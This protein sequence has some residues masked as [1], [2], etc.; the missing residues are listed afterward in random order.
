ML[1]AILL[2][3]V[4]SIYGRKVIIDCDAGVDDI[5][6]IQLLLSEPEVE[7]LAITT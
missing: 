6:A 1:F 5:Y 2:I 4:N 3:L 7:I